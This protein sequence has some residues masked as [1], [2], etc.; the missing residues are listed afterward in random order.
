MGAVRRR[1]GIV[2]EHIAQASQ[3]LRHHRI[4]GFFHRGKA[5]VFHQHDRLG[6][7]SFNRRAAWPLHEGHCAAKGRL[8]RRL[9][10]LQA[11]LGHDLA[12][13]ASE[14]RQQHHAPA[15]GQ[16][17]AY[18]RHDLVDPGCVGH[19]G[20]LHRHVDIDPRQ[21]DLAR[22]IHIIHRFPAHGAS[23]VPISPLFRPFSRQGQPFPPF[24]SVR[25]T[26]GW[27]R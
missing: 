3:K 23:P 4:I 1:K 10:Q 7:Q 9:H 19:N 8:Q 16:N 12:L 2:A 11:H 21:H 20:P 6:C 18:R 5:G 14:M 22:Q 24:P 15:L 17:V 26:L 13:G 25:P 27:A